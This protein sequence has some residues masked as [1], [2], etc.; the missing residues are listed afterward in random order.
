MAFTETRRLV[1]RTHRPWLRVLIFSS[2]AVIAIASIYLAFEFGRLG[3]GHNSLTAWQQR[4]ELQSTITRLE[5]DNAS[6]R[7]RIAELE[8][9]QVSGGQERSELARTV[10]ELQS[11]VA[12]QNQDLTFYRG[13]VAAS[14]GGTSVRI[15]RVVIAPGDSANNFALRVVLVQT[16]RAEKNISGTMT[17]S[18]SGFEQNNPVTYTL[19]RLSA[20]K[21]TQLKFSFRY[22]EDIDQP[23]ALPAG[24]I[25]A[26]IQVEVRAE[27]RTGEPLTET[28]PWNVQQN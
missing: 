23:L 7:A 24:F 14:A 9:G 13:I 22:F 2:L 21:R 18:V 19:D 26:K 27:G 16:A 11:Q 28:F 10:S 5:K 17:L 3:A 8:T 25:P 12:R 4:R 15:Q 20:D 6:L 1:I